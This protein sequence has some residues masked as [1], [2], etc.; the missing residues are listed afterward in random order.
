MLCRIAD[1]DAY[2]GRQKPAAST[3]RGKRGSRAESIS[4]F[5]QEKVHPFVTGGG[6]KERQQKDIEILKAKKMTQE[7]KAKKK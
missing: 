1:P 5:W 6:A 2:Y 4:R 3:R 7:S